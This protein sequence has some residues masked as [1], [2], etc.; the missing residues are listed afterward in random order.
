MPAASN[1]NTQGFF[2]IAA[3]Q[4]GRDAGG[5]DLDQSKGLEIAR[6][7]SCAYEHHRRFQAAGRLRIQSQSRSAAGFLGNTLNVCAQT[8]GAAMCASPSTAS[9]SVLSSVA[10]RG[11]LYAEINLTETVVD[12]VKQ[13][14]KTA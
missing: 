11:T 6:A 4:P 8:Q 10:M 5:F 13:R 7:T 1:V 3:N 14:D 2:L 12:M 9:W